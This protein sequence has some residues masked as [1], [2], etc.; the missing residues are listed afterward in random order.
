MLG[1][2]GLIQIGAPADVYARPVSLWSARLTGPAS[3]LTA[4]VTPAAHDT[5]KVRVGEVEIRIAA[6]G[7]GLDG[8][9][10]GKRR[11]LL[12]PDWTSAGG[13]LRGRLHAVAFRGPHTDHVVEVGSDLVLV[14]RPGPPRQRVGDLF[15]WSIDH[16]WVLPDGA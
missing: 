13:P 8:S 15:S 16:A 4:V 5:M 6:A 10:S 14:R 9:A 1:A 7:A 11:V 12:R 2:G 3:V